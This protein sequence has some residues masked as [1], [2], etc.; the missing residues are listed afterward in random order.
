[1]AMARSMQ[2]LPTSW[3]SPTAL[4]PVSRHTARVRAVIGFVMLK[5]QAS[6]QWSSMAAPMPTS[7]GMLRSARL[8]PPGPTVSP[9]A[10]L[11]PLAAGTSR[12]T[13][14]ERKP[15]VEMHTMTKSA[16]SRAAPRS[17]VVVTVA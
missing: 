9:T 3:Q 14:M 2:K 11:I 4:I 16:P 17:V 1:M 15:P 6:G 7:T 13:A 8:M 10:C 5:S 12:S